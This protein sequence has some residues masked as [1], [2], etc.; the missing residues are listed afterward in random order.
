MSEKIEPVLTAE[1]WD[2]RATHRSG[3]FADAGYGEHA[4]V[5]PHVGEHGESVLRIHDSA[6]M[7]AR[8]SGHHCT[9][10]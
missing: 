3:V 6:W 8:R 10:E 4:M 9:G 2:A 1:E 7:A 5:E